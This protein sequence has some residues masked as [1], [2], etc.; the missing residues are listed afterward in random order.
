[1]THQKKGLSEQNERGGPL[2]LGRENERDHFVT[3][4]QQGHIVAREG[5]HDGGGV[6]ELSLCGHGVRNYDYALHP[7]QLMRSTY[8]SV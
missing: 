3:L 5:G 8:L 4:I 7:L 2:T 1:V 6:N